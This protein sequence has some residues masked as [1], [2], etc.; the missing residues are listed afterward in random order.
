MPT[1]YPLLPLPPDQAE[2]LGTLA[3][4][5]S[6]AP[7]P[8]TAIREALDH[9]T[10]A[11]GAGPSMFTLARPGES[12]CLVVSDHTRKTAAELVLPVL[13]RGWQERGCRLTDV[14][15]VVAS[16][17]HRHSTP[18]ELRKIL[19][20]D[21]ATPFAGRIFFHDPDDARGLVAVGRT[22]GGREVRIN[23]RA[24]EADRL[25]LLGAATYHY[26][27]GFGGGRKSLVPGLA[28]RSTIAY[29]HSLTLDP[30]QDRIRPGVEIG[31]LDGN[32]V[33]EEM[34][35]GARLCQPDGIV[36]TVISPAGVLVGVH[37]GE[38][39]LA[40]R[41]ACRQLEQT[42]RVDLERPAD[43]VIASAGTA[44]NWIQSHKALFNASRA[45]KP[46]GRIVLL[47][48]CPEGLGNEQ[49]RHWVTR[50][51]L[52]EIYA[53]LRKSPEVLGQTA[54][55]TRTRGARAILVTGLDA[56]DRADLGI[57]TAPD[58]EAAARRVLAD[59]HAA[60]VRRPSY[61]L[62]PEALSLVPFAARTWLGQ[63]A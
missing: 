7:L 8:E 35:E 46:E 22:R 16:G 17:I 23:R 36:N 4:P 26:H 2:Y 14:F 13:L 45:V 49:F 47:A 3:S 51:S 29:N 18:D 33:S 61:Y 42:A 1:S 32:P 9:P 48:P 11:N 34:L 53:G 15:I 40:H 60:G 21:V 52:A 59:F 58:L 27:A 25:I 5:S 31:R 56:R 57:S 63:D 6:A 39:D 37:A 43:F 55:S 20:A 12:V 54:L 28:S 19:G 44:S 10:W 62:M 41:A 38:L 50:P 30:V 24:V